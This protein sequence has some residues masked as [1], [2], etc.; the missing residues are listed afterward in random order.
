VTDAALHVEVHG[1]RGPHLLLVHGMLASRAQWQPNLP[2]L[3]RVCRPVVVELLGHGRSPSPEDPSCYAPAAYAAHFERVREGLG[4]PAWFVCGT[5]LGAAITLRYALDHPQRVLAHAFTNTNSALADSAWVEQTRAAMRGFQA[6]VEA[7]GA[8][9]LERLP[10]HPKHA[11]RLPVETRDRLVADASL[12]SPQGVARTALH[13]VVE[14][15]VRDEVSS[16]AVPML[17]LYGTREQRFAEAAQ[18]ARV[19]IPGL[20]VVELDVGHAVNLEAPREFEAALVDF[21]AR[22]G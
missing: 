2:A 4:V 5:S 12:H 3:C 17:M 18:H 22:A 8:A 1:D 6:S 16:A 15:S 20:E 11:R 19:A 13:T 14:S 10:V 7:E 9:V 21:L